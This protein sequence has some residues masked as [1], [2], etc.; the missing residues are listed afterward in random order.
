MRRAVV[1]CRL[2][3]GWWGMFGTR[4][5]GIGEWSFPCS[6]FLIRTVFELRD[7]P[8]GIKDAWDLLHDIDRIPKEAF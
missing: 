6:H 2:G 5:I 3:S 1:G 8:R 7:F 4:R